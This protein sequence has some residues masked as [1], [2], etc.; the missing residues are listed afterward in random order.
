[1]ETLICLSSRR[2]YFSRSFRRL[3]EGPRTRRRIRAATRARAADGSGG[4]G[5]RTYSPNAAR[6]ARPNDPRG[7]EA[8]RPLTTTALQQRD[9]SDADSGPP[10]AQPPEGF[11]D[12]DISALQRAQKRYA[13]ARRTAKT[14]GGRFLFR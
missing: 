6:Q 7:A 11:R 8:F 2:I 9:A 1:M 5:L 3:V 12:R 14:R 13:S 4:S 10:R